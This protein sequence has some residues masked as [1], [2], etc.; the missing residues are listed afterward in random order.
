VRH[1]LV[2]KL[3]LVSAIATLAALALM[4]ASIVWPGP[5][6]LVA[7]MSVGQGL[8]TLSL[9]LYLL[10]IVLDLQGSGAA[11]DRV[12]EARDELATDH[13]P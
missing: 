3:V 6:L 9:A 5:L 12:A 4:G 13:K 8:G 10:A 7:A 11:F 1:D 2:K